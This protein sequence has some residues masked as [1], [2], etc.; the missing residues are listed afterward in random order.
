MM[1]NNSYEIINYPS[2]LNW[3][4]STSIHL[5]I[6]TILFALLYLLRSYICEGQLAPHNLSGCHCLSCHPEAVRPQNPG[7]HTDQTGASLCICG[8]MDRGVCLYRGLDVSVCLFVSVSVRLSVCLCV[9]SCYKTR[10][11]DSFSCTH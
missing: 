4:Y 9:L 8:W 10:R 3:R 5:Q 1:I 11:F 2:N 6:L 7:P